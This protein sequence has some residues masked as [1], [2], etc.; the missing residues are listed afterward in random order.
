MMTATE[1]F[2]ADLERAIQRSR[3]AQEE[4]ESLL[5]RPRRS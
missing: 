2:L 1:A 3:K 4:A 5:R